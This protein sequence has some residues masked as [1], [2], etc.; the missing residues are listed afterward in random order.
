MWRAVRPS[1]IF[2][3]NWREPW[4]AGS[5]SPTARSTG[6][7]SPRPANDTTFRFSR[8]SWLD[9]QTVVRRTWPQ[10]AR[11]GYSLGNLA[12]HFGIE[13]RHHD[14]LE[15]AVATAHIFRRALA[16]ERAVRER[17]G[18]GDRGR[19]P[20]SPSLLRPGR[21]RRP[22]LGQDGGL[23]RADADRPPGGS[24]AGRRTGLQRRRSRIS[25]HHVCS[26][27]AAKGLGPGR[28]RRNATRNGSFP[29]AIRSRSSPR[30]NS[31]GCSRPE[32]PMSRSTDGALI[33]TDGACIGSGRGCP[34]GYAA[35]ILLDGREQVV[36]RPKLGHDEHRHGAHG[37]NR[38]LWKPSLH[39]FPQPFIATASMWSSAPPSALPWWRSR[40]WRIIKGG[41]LANRD[42]WR[43]LSALQGERAVDLALGQGP[44]GRP[45]ERAGACPGLW[46]GP[47]A[48]AVARQP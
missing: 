32:D 45:G 19:T 35:L 7:R 42:L 31:G 9:N 14:A 34:G 38:A 3:R 15:D 23:H 27:L 36:A 18:L 44:C 30:A 37:S 24:P 40:G 47:L 10:F 21:E 43:R 28:A 17:L 16:R 26:A 4:R 22:L 41:K 25:R 6:S 29:A 8:P 11:K 12:R 33:Y 5:S 13:F 1:A 48:A 20:P 46:P 2:C 39:A